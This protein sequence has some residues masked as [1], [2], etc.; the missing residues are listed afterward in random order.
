MR[1]VRDGA[2]ILRRYLL[3]FVIT[4]SKDETNALGPLSVGEG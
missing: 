4:T 1:G 3:I 2:G